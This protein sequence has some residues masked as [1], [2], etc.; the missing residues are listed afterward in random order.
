MGE[1]FRPGK[2]STVTACE[3]LLDKNNNRPARGGDWRS[4]GSPEWMVVA[5][6]YGTRDPDQRQQLG[7]GCL[8]AVHARQ[9]IPIDD[10]P[11]REPSRDLPVATR[12]TATRLAHGFADGGA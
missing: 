11:E 3:A 1:L 10:R 6:A 2:C 4:R 12:E 8:Q 5:S 9:D 7:R